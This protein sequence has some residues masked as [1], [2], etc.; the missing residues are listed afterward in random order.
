[1]EMHERIR[2]LRKEYLRLS[3]TAFGERLGVSRDVIKNIELNALARP[4]QKLSLIK[5]ICKEFSVSEEWILNGVE[6][7][8]I[9][10]DTFR[11]DDFVRQHNGTELELEIMKAYFELEPDVRQ[12]LIQHF[13]SIFAK[14]RNKDK[15]EPVK[16][17]PL[18]EAEAAYIKSRSK[19][20]KK[21][22]QYVSNTTVNTINSDNNAEKAANQ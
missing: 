7:M 2:Y 13:S 6:P 10:P 1:M 3:Q 4:E 19:T 5:L 22:E 21:T 18:E 16:P 12:N 17:T 20:A 11:L 14:S 9:E 15:D 8:I